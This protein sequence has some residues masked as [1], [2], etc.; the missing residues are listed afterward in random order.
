[1]NQAMAAGI[2][3]VASI[4]ITFILLKVVDAV[5]GLRVTEDEELQGLDVSLH[6]EEG[7]AEDHGGMLA[8]ASHA[9]AVHSGSAAVSTQTA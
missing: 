5:V 4:I 2:T 1:V 9:S 7:Y 6:G 3:I 8:P